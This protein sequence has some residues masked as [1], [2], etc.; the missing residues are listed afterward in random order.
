MTSFKLSSTFSPRTATGSIKQLNWF[1]FFAITL[2]A[3]FSIVHFLR[4]GYLLAAHWS[5][6]SIGDWAINFQ[7]GL[8]RRGLSGEIFIFLTKL[9]GASLNWVVFTVQCIAYISYMGLFLFLLRKKKVTFWYFV[10]CFS[11]GFLLFNY[12]DG[13]S[14]GRKEIL[15][16]LAFMLWLYF[17]EYRQESRVRTIVFSI[18]Y[19]FLTLIHEVFFFYAPYFCVATSLYK[20]R[21][22]PNLSWLIP[23]SATFAILM[24]LVLSRPLD[25]AGVCNSLIQIGAAATVCDG[26]INFGTQSTAALTYDFFNNFGQRSLLALS[27][28][29][30]VVLLPAHLILRDIDTAGRLQRSWSLALIALLGFSLPLFILAA[31]WGRWVSTHVTLSLFMLLIAL[32]PKLATIDEPPS[33]PSLSWLPIKSKVLSLS[34]A[35][36][37]FMVFNLSY[38]FNHCCTNDLLKPLGPVNRILNTSLFK[39]NH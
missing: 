15:L 9:T 8:T 1:Y 11:P 36:I 17:A 7:A 24:T 35:L 39:L 26:P 34:L 32:K 29:I 37:C 19:F 10:A 22:C 33:V 13:I 25:S 31:D 23:A 12:Y 28:G 3:L 5:A 14:V 4:V 27:F 16:Y 2:L 38:S 18:C 30:L 21:W 6:W 20:S